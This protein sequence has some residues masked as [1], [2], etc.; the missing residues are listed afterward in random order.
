MKTL[1]SYLPFLL[2]AVCA[3]AQT[4]TATVVGRVMDRSGSAVM[5]ATVRVRNVDTNEMRTIATGAGGDYTVPALAPGNYEVSVEKT[6]FKLLR[7]EHLVLQ[8]GQTARV[9][10]SLQLGSTS[11]SVDV[12]AVVPL[13]NTETAARGEVIAP[14]ELTQMPLNG[15]D[16]N[17]LAFMVPGVQ[18]AEQGSKGSPYV[19][20]GARADASNVT[21][22][23]FNDQNPRDAGAQARPPLEALQEFKLQTSGY[24]AE[25]GRLA[26]GVVT[27][28]LKSGGNLLHGAVF[29]YLRNDLFDARNFFDAVKSKLRRNQFGASFT[30]PVV[31]P[32]LYDGHDKTFFLASWESFR[33][34][35]GSSQLGVIPSDLERQGD[36]SQSFGSNGKLV[37]LKDPLSTAACTAAGGP[38]CFPGNVIPAG[39][40]SPIARQLAGIFPSPNATGA[41]NYR[42]N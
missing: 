4:P 28:A 26:G 7:Q 3:G 35:A 2:F 29:E 15:R 25:Y 17:D 30:G 40:I 24:S 12:E 23:G 37:A 10:A 5:A 39:R 38:G 8:V 21:I 18:A 34:V 13:V 1:Q 22:D 11:Q 14:A 9:D 6:G 33:G 31:I 19:V 32:R 20:N 42:A 36:F 41:N 16:F 27:M